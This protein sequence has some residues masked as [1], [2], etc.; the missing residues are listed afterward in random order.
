MYVR[1]MAIEFDFVRVY[2]NIVQRTL[3]HRFQSL[4]LLNVKGILLS[5][6]S[7]SHFIKLSL[8]ISF[9]ENSLSNF[10]TE[11]ITY[12][13]IREKANDVTNNRIGKNLL[14]YCRIKN[15]STPRILVRQGTHMHEIMSTCKDVLSRNSRING[16]LE[17]P[18]LLAS[19]KYSS[20]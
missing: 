20:I 18:P 12:Y 10:T 9:C 15:G 6:A 1:K 14:N 8:S 19:F 3:G 5:I 7:A 2:I 16:R 11:L 13:M 4:T 17:N